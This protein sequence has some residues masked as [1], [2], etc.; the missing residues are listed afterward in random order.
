M[1]VF[2][3]FVCFLFSFF[4]LFLWATTGEAEGLLLVLNSGF[5]PGQCPRTTWTA[6]GLSLDVLCM[7][8]EY[9]TIKLILWPLQA[10]F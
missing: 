9:L 5:T 4:F 8:G 10:V 1:V 7:Q 6:R 2:F 3:V